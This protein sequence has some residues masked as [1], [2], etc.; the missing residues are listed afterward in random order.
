MGCQ[1]GSCPHKALETRQPFSPVPA[2]FHLQNGQ[3]T[4][5]SSPHSQLLIPETERERWRR[6]GGRGERETFSFQTS[7]PGVLA[8]TSPLGPNARQFVT[9]SSWTF[10][11]LFPTHTL[12]PAP[13]AAPQLPTDSISPISF[14]LSAAIPSILSPEPF[15][16]ALLHNPL[17]LPSCPDLS[18]SLPTD[19]LFLPSRTQFCLW[20]HSTGL[21]SCSPPT[22][23]K[24]SR[25]HRV[26]CPSS[27]LRFILLDLISCLSFPSDL[28]TL[29]SKT[30]VPDQQSLPHIAP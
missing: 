29:P 15:P 26:S 17:P 18:H 14:P 25:V 16:I 23:C 7:C 11:L 12:F 10:F 22:K 9:F 3:G 27:A 24:L 2:G 8:F 21:P 20:L 30:F 5:Q 6:D 4:L 13:S 1:P 28:L 19:L